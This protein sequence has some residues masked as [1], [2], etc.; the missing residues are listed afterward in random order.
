MAINFCIV[1]QLAWASCVDARTLPDRCGHHG[2]QHTRP[3]LRR[4]PA[5]SDARDAFPSCEFDRLFCLLLRVSA[6]RA[7][8]TEW[9]ELP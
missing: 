9:Q 6:A 8:V 3:H 4:R 5:A 2:S 7:C 1:S